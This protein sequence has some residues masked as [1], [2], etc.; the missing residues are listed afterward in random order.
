MATKKKDPGTTLQAIEK[1][2]AETAAVQATLAAGI[3][4]QGK[5]LDA[6]YVQTAAPTETREEKKR[7]KLLD[8]MKDKNSRAH[9]VTVDFGGGTIAQ[10]ST[11]LLNWG[12][13]AMG[14]WSPDGFVAQ[15]NDILQSAPHWLLGLG[16]YIAEMAT[17]K[18]G[19]FPS[20]TREVVS[21]ASKLFA[22][23]GFSNLVRALR[24]RYSDGKQKDLDIAALQAEKAE[25]QK[26]LQQIQQP[27]SGR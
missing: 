3:E 16:I 13:R 5:A 1:T 12:V 4:Q 24:V 21:E 23:L 6:A 18:N 15:N 20:T 11:E 22:Q 25:L 7:V 26:R 10:V 14:R 19:E 27:P 17:R 9:R 8:S 2:L